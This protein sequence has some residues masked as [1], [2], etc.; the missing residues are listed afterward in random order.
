MIADAARHYDLLQR[1]IDLVIPGLREAEN[2]EP[3]G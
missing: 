1:T 3:R 2:P